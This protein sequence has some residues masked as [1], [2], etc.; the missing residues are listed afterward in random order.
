MLQPD[1]L[2]DLMLVDPC[3]QARSCDIAPDRSCPDRSTACSSGNHQDVISHPIRW[4]SMGIRV[5]SAPCILA[6]SMGAWRCVTALNCWLHG[7]PRDA[8]CSAMICCFIARFQALQTSSSTW[9]S[10]PTRLEIAVTKSEGSWAHPELSILP[11]NG[12]IR[13]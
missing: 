4:V 5:A 12:S 3:R 6:R 11:Y 9:R 2:S 8:G 7:R 13:N 1:R 10:S